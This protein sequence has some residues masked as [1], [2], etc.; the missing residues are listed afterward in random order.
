V[1]ATPSWEVKFTCHIHTA[2]SILHESGAFQIQDPKPES[3]CEFPKH[4]T[5][6]KRMQLNLE[7][8][9]NPGFKI[10]SPITHYDHKY[11]V[12]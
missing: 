10:V 9:H 2:T 11:L 5:T 1:S 12:E 4:S 6:S 7:T 3:P 8:R